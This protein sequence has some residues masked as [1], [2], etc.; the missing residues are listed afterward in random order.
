MAA[1][2]FS[3]SSMTISDL[4]A[5]IDSGMDGGAL[6]FVGF[7]TCFGN[8][9][10]LCYE[11][12]SSALL[13]AGTPALVP[14]GGWDYTA[15]LE[16]FA[17]SDGSAL[18]LSQAALRQFKDSYASYGHA[19]FSVVSLPEIQDVV[20]SFDALARAAANTVHDEGAARHYSDLCE[21][22]IRSYCAAEFPCDY[23]LDV[24]DFSK[25]LGEADS[26]LCEPARALSE[27]LERAVMLSWSADG[28][29][30]SFGVFYSDFEAAACPSYTH[31][32]LYVNGSR[33]TGQCRFVRD[34]SGYV[35]TAAR[36]GSF[37]D[38]VFYKSY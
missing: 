28:G 33:E 37:L 6:D 26:A 19:C 23:F 10:E 8:C 9:L 22:E 18:A 14:A 24:A 12:S 7:D 4:R 2:S 15:F 1:D 34:F 13:L 31:P 20:Q 17:A 30:S 36:S 3:D 29:E 5:A 35:P 25:K 11:L 27:S 16:S 21:R 38:T 32:P